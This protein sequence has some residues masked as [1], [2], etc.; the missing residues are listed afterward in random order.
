MAVNLK[1]LN[2]ERQRKLSKK[3]HYKRI[4][5]STFMDNVNCGYS[6]TVNNNLV[7]LPQVAPVKSTKNLIYNHD[8]KSLGHQ[9]KDHPL[10]SKKALFIFPSPPFRQNN[11]E[12]MWRGRL[13]PNQHCSGGGEGEMKTKITFQQ[14]SKVSQDL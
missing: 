1:L 6:I 8:H 14:D 12:I 10:A 5:S 13:V 9:R 11:V 2:A 7:V 3:T 4:G